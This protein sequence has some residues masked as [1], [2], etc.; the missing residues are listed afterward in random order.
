MKLLL[1]GFEPFGGSAI[2]P[3][4]Q[5]VHALAADPPSGME[6]STAILPV[7]RSAGP[8]ALL[9]A[10]TDHKPDVVICLGEATGRAVIS[11]ERLAVNL[12]DYRIPDNK[13]EQAVDQPIRADGPD[14]YFATLPVRKLQEAVTAAGIPCELSLSAGAYLCNQVMYTLLDHAACERPGMTGGFIHLPCLPMQASAR[15]DKTPSMGLDTILSALRAAISAL[16]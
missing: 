12:L 14:A 9:K 16:L 10:I 13:G 6:L 15:A 2:N 5:A 11:I 8:D 7:D 4:E 1:T 3:S